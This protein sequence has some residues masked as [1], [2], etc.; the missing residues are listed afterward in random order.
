MWA[1]D[2][3]SL[4]KALPSARWCHGQA[5]GEGSCLGCGAYL[6]SLSSLRPRGVGIS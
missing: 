5:L 1:L 6:S 3:C 2:L 4:S